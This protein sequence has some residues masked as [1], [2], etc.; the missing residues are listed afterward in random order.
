MKIGLFDLNKSAFNK[1]RY[2]YPEIDLMKVYSYYNRNK[3]NVIELS[4]DYHK[5]KDYDLYYCFNNSRHQIGKDLLNLQFQENVY[6]VGTC[7]YGDTWIPMDDEIEHCEPDVQIYASYLRDR[8]L[9]EKS[10]EGIKQLVDG[11]YYLRYYYPDWH[12]KIIPNKIKNKRVIFYDF[13][14][15][16]HEG[17]QDL[18][19]QT[20]QDSGRNIAFRHKLELNSLE[21]LQFAATNKMYLSSTKYPP[22]FVIN[23]PD[24]WKDFPNFFN[25]YYE[26]FKAFPVRSLYIYSN[27]IKDDSEQLEKLAQVCDI[28]MYAL[29]KKVQIYPI[30]D[31][32]KLRR[33]YDLFLRRLDFF[34]LSGCH[35]PI[36]DELCNRGDPSELMS[37]IKEKMP[38]FYEKINTIHRNDVKIGDKEWLYGER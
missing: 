16:S 14:F 38:I 20:R 33:E 26:Y 28:C 17:W 5:Y 10:L 18:F 27:H 7:F 34:F 12:W 3:Q 19:L 25:E 6:L 1:S 8:I 31:Y 24:I 13:N 22:K 21:D 30:F 15:T 32:S 23:I 2:E 36:V 11:N 29:G 35:G 9:N 37:K 4:L